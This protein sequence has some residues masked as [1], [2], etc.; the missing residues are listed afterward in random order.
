MKFLLSAPLSQGCSSYQ[1]YNHRQEARVPV[2]LSLLERQTRNEQEEC[3]RHGLPMA[4]VKDTARWAAH[5]PEVGV[6]G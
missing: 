6:I 5:S 2:S 1:A 3:L 4:A